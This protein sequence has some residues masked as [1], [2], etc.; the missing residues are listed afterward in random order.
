M[1]KNK[2]YCVSL[3]EDLVNWSEAL[4]PD[5]NM[6]TRVKKALR[7]YCSRQWEENT[8]GKEDINDAENNRIF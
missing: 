8:N 5:E 4:F 3:P 6:S 2:R 1:K 7:S